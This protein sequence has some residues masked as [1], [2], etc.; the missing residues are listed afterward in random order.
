MDGS[1]GKT[2]VNVTNFR[3]NVKYKMR[4]NENPI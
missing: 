2:V 3:I 4:M 1:N